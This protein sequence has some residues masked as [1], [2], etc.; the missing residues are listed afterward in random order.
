[1]KAWEKELTAIG[2]IGEIVAESIVNYF[3]NGDNRKMIKELRKSGIDPRSARRK[4]T[5]LKGKTFVFT[6]SLSDMTRDEAKEKV[7]QLGAKATG[8]VSSKT[9]FVV[10]GEDPGSKLD[11]AKSLDIRVLDEKD[12]RKLLEEHA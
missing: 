10:A 4:D 11:K 3:E 2:D 9:D 12:F 7:R 1:M 6:G 8:S 5:V